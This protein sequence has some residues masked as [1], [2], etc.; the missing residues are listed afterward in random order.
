MLI[1][2]KTK[3]KM[4]KKKKSKRRTCRIGTRSNFRGGGKIKRR[5]RNVTPKRKR[6]PNGRKKKL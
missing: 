2:K 3:Y 6:R 5:T 4:F 1:I